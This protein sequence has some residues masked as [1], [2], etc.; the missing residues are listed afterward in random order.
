[1]QVMNQCTDQE[2]QSGEKL[3]NARE[4]HEQL[5][6]MIL[7]RKGSHN[8][9]AS[10]VRR[11]EEL[12]ESKR[13]VTPHVIQCVVHCALLLFSCLIYRSCLPSQF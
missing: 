12:L 11:T 13:E 6:E 10:Q 2:N 1:M 5:E 9:I 7:E 4:S 3:I 8:M